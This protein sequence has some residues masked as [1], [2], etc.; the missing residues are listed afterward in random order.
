MPDASS[1][2][3]NEACP[4]SA[5]NI[6]GLVAMDFSEKHRNDP[7]HSRSTCMHARIHPVAQ[8]G[9]ARLVACGVIRQLHPSAHLRDWALIAGWCRWCLSCIMIH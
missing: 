1:L 4:P 5:M 8:T 9:S 2:Q 6:D 3:C 7:W